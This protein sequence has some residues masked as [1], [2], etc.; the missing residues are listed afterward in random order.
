MTSPTE[1]VEEVAWLSED[2]L[3]DWKSLVRLLMTLPPALDAQLKRDAGLNVYEY[4]VLAALS[5]APERSLLMS[6][7]AALAHASASRLSHAVS[8]LE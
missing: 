7:L 4:H 6:E 1:A 8:R 3:D 2:Q 5:T